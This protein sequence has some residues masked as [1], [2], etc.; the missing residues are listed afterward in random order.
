MKFALVDGIRREA[1]PGLFGACPIHGHPMVARCGEVRTRHWAHQGSRSCD[2]WWENET[3][4]HRAWK[5]QFPEEWQEIVHHS[6]EGEKHVAD[7]KTDR[8]W[9]I[10]FQNSYIKPEERRSREAFYGQLIWVVNGL[11]RKRDA[12][13][14]LSAFNA[15]VPIGGNPLIRKA[16]S[17]GCAFLRE[18]SNSA[19][20]VF[21]DFGEEPRIWWLLNKSPSKPVYIM[22]F[23]RAEFIRIHR[24]RTTPNAHDFDEVMK[25][26]DNL[27]AQYE[28][29]VERLNRVSP[30]PLQ[31]FDRYSPRRDFR[32]RRF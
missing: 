12:V 17:D 27:I 26:I 23:S 30:G 32:R 2:L 18:W 10:E 11:R 4:W 25:D 14:F 3:E 16:F 7:V 28:V 8:E 31:L 6:K 19:S 24:D 5:G 9:V 29:A 22:A 21:L 15:G 13:Q 20:P 1:E